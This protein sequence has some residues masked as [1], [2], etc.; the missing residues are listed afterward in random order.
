[1]KFHRN[2]RTNQS[3]WKAEKVEG[4]S[5]LR[6]FIVLI[7]SILI[8]SCSKTREEDANIEL[9]KTCYFIDN[10]GNDSIIPLDSSFLEYNKKNIAGKIA[11]GTKLIDLGTYQE[12]SFMSDTKTNRYAK[13][14]TGKYKGRKISFDYVYLDNLKTKD[15]YKQID[16]KK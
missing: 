3:T 12:S 2:E 11:E 13:I 16:K 5:I 1:M 10:P 9:L 15:I 6:L 14:A 7:I 4:M 8:L